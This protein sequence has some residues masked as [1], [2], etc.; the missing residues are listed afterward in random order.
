VLPGGFGAAKNLSDFA[1]KGPESSVQV[2]VERLVLAA[3]KAGKPICAICIAPA[4]VA[5]V[6]GAAGIS[7]KVTIGNDEATAQAIEATGCTHVDCA[8]DDFILDESLKLVTTPAYM[9][10]QSIS[11][12]AA[13]IEKAIA[14]TLGL[15]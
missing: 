12:V 10:G 6:L 7:A 2:D 9:L 3:Q 1:V 11:D 13:G 8:V 14:K 15:V 4:V 5:R